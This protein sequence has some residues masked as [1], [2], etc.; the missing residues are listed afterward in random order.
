MQYMNFNSSC[1]FC[2]VANLLELQGRSITDGQLFQAMRVEWL[3]NH[4]EESGAWE[5][6]AML[7]SG[8]YFDL[9]LRPLGFSL[10]EVHGLSAEEVLAQEPGFMVGLK[11]GQGGR[12]ARVLLE[13]RNGSLVFLNP[14]REGDGE[15]D[16]V[17]LTA[18]ECLQRLEESSTVG[19]LISCPAKETDF[20]PLLAEARVNWRTYQEE[21]TAF[22]SQ[23]HPSGDILAERDRL[24]RALLLD[25]PEG[26]RLCGFR[27]QEARLRAIQGQFLGALR[28]EKP[29]C[30]LEYMDMDTLEAAFAFY[31]T[32]PVSAN[33]MGK[34]S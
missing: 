28:G 32:G 1:A 10:Q 3:L 9:A 23:P 18:E 22:I 6:G 26:A 14:H 25:G 33:D 4:S 16:L 7:Q 21:L 29:V 13:R 11:T 5:T 17:I 30:L 27:E 8:R 20:R 2:C 19:R 31:M 12:H 24:F 34:F 15:P